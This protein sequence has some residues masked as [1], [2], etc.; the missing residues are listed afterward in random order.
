MSVY[1]TARFAAKDDLRAAGLIKDRPPGSYPQGLMIGWWIDDIDSFQP[2][3]YTGDLHQLIVAGTGGGKFTTALAPLIMGSVMNNTVVVVDPKGEIANVTGP[4]WEVPFRDEPTVYLFDPWDECKT[5]HCSTLNVLDQLTPSNPNYVDDARALADALVIPSGG[6]NTH[7]DNAARNFLTAVLLYVA[8]SPEEKDRRDLLRVRELVTMPWAMPKTY[9]GP[10]RETLSEHLYLRWLDSDLA[11]GA[12]KRGATGI[13]NREEKE[14]SGIISSIERDTA[15]IDSPQMKK[16][17][18]G[19][20]IDLTRVGRGGDKYYIV[21]PPAFFMTHRGWLRLMVTTFASVLK[22][23][24]STGQAGT[25]HRFRHIIIDEFANLGEMNFVLNDIAVARGFDVKYH[26][27]IQDL[28][29]LA[30]VY[31]QGWE[32]FINNTFQRFFAVSDMF[33]AEYV[34]RMLGGTTVHSVGLSSGSSEGGSYADSTGNTQGYSFTTGGMGQPSSRTTNFNRNSG[35]SFNENFGT[36]NTRSINPAQRPLHT[37]DEV[38]RLANNAQYL[39]IRGMYP[40][41][42]WRP[43]YWKIFHTLPKHSLKEVMDTIGK[44]RP[45]DNEFDYYAYWHFQH[46][47]MIPEKREVA[48]PEPVTTVDTPP[49]PA[50]EQP[51]R[52]PTEAKPLSRVRVVGIF[53]ILVFLYFVPPWS[54]GDFVT[55]LGYRIEDA[56]G[57][58]RLGPSP[59]TSFAAR[60]APAQSA[61]NPAASSVRRA[62]LPNSAALDAMP[63]GEKTRD[64]FVTLMD[65]NIDRCAPGHSEQERQMMAY[66]TNAAIRKRVPPPKLAEEVTKLHQKGLSND[67]QNLLAKASWSANDRLTAFGTIKNWIRRNYPSDPVIDQTV[68]RLYSNGCPRGAVAEA[69]YIAPSYAD[70]RAM[71]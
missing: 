45:P 5:G 24:P 38:R 44:P 30:R 18:R 49:L 48:A 27:A 7:W 60:S 50:K 40:I 16:V 67:L 32:S 37:P 34:S 13:L 46:R 3:E 26:L 58:L 2:I 21:L 25:Y 1:G 55:Y 63:I 52:E 14:R 10:K 51:K 64:Y 47:L 11:D 71:R 12:I 33:T 59:P 66:L 43:P 20:G 15:W 68:R 17:L 62:P 56:K 61:A 22:R 42:C 65:E 8:L 28:S 19:T 9:T 29:Q 31:A 6:E 70:I 57:A 4:Y 39:F 53:C 41:E 54:F 69:A 35:Q 36:S 23:N